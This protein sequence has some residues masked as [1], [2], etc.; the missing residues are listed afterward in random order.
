MWLTPSNFSRHYPSVQVSAAS[1]EELS[2]LLG[3]REP[4]LMLKSK[5]LLYETC[6]RA[7]RRVYWLRL[8]CGQILK[9]SL[10]NTFAHEWV[11]FWAV[12]P[13]SLSALPDSAKEQMIPGICGRPSK[14]ALKQSS[15]YAAFSK[16]YQA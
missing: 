7:W 3:Q 16:M 4:L 10:S 11:S 6:L 13:V 9:P 2:E 12:I 5:P 14:E 1:I 8:L 15:L